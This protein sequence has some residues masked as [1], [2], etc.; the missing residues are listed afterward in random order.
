MAYDLEGSYEEAPQTMI[1]NAQR[2]RRWCQGNLQH[3]WWCGRRGLR[4]V[5]P[6]APGPWAYLVTWPARCGCCFLLT[7]NWMLW[8]YR[9]HTGLSKITVRAFT[10][11]LRVSATRAR[12]PHFRPLHGRAFSA[13]GAG[14]GGSGVGQGTRRRAFGGMT[15]ATVRR[16]GGNGFFRAARSV[17]NAVALANLW[18]PRCWLRAFSGGRKS[19]RPMA[20]AWSRGGRGNIGRIR[21]HRLDLGG[22]DLAAGSADLLV[23]RAGDGGDGLEHS[24]E[25]A[26]QPGQPG[27]AGAATGAFLDTRRDRATAG[28]GRLAGAHGGAGGGSGQLAPRAPDSG[29]ADAV[30]GPVRQRHPR[31]A[32]AGEAAETRLTRGRWRAWAWAGR[33]CGP[34]ARSC[35]RK[36]RSNCSRSEKLLI[37]SDAE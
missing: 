18:P 30:S 37:M 13:Q 19:A 14:A 17:A 1:E 9:A 3:A 25:R 36:G 8:Y 33:K 20:S 35:W 27:R 5:Q 12:L 26:D 29:L 22:G 16:R 6:P 23:V 11:F 4:G 31:F 32:V 2:D 15:H 21:L 24:A 10:P 34:C 28:A 7:F